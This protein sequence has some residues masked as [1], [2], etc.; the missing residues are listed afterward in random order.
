MQFVTLRIDVGL[1]AI[2]FE[3]G[4]HIIIAMSHLAPMHIT[5]HLYRLPL[6]RLLGELAVVRHV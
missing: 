6:L 1:S 3:S 5:R 2:A 4:V